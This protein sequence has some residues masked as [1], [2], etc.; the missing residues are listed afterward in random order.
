MAV[1][2]NGTTGID[3]IQDGTVSTTKIVA[4][5]VTTPKIADTVNLGRRNLIINGAMQIYQRGQSHP[6]SNGYG[7][8]DRWFIWG[9][10]GTF[11]RTSA[12]L[13]SGV[14]FRDSLQATSMTGEWIIAQ[15]IDLVYT[16]NAGIFYNGQTITLSY[17]A[18]STSASD[19]LYNFIAF[20]DSVS[21]STNQSVV[22][23]DNTDT[24]Q[25]STSWQRFTKTYT[26][27]VSPAG[28]NTCLVVMPRSGSTPAGDIY[29]TGI[30]LETGDTATPYEHINSTE[31]LQNCQRYY[32][33]SISNNGGSYSSTGCPITL[34]HTYTTSTAAWEW[35]TFQL[36]VTM[37]GTPNIT[38][39]DTSGNS[40][41]VS[42]F[43][44]GGGS[45][46]TNHTPYQAGANK[47]HVYVNVYNVGSIY[48]FMC[49]ITADAEL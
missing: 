49:H 22:D 14:G 40:G 29:I 35:E 16:G 7:S 23:S 20:R 18:K 24:N 47:S 2:I 17:Y 1:V 27:G 48:G 13:P 3:T 28:T 43:T 33:S 9:T 12:S 45:V 8:V 37:R 21:S 4:D 19:T 31:E 30:Q 11:T 25:L 46:T 34:Y 44:S 36:P 6:S 5:A 42:H 26:I 38:T 15:G 39:Y 10:N 41:K 32:F